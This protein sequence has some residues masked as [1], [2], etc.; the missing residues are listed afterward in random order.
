MRF[1]LRTLLIV[2]AVGPVVLA[3]ALWQLQDWKA[4]RSKAEAAAVWHWRVAS[5][6]ILTDVKLPSI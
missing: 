4:R 1:R 6:R 5:A 2:L 3:V